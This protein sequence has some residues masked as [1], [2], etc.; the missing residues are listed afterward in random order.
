MPAVPAPQKLRKGN[1]NFEISEPRLHSK[2]LCKKKI[3]VS[4]GIWI[5]GQLGPW[6]VSPFQEYQEGASPN[7][8]LLTPGIRTIEAAFHSSVRFKEQGPPDDR[9]VTYVRIQDK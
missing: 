4:R 8:L 1:L 5:M 9:T 2:T 7:Q 6:T 3:E